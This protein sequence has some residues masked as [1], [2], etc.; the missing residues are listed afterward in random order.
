VFV[1]VAPGAGVDVTKQQV[2]FRDPSPSRTSMSYYTST[3]STSTAPTIVDAGPVY[4]SGPLVRRHRSKSRTGRELRADVRA[5]ESELRHSHS[6]GRHGE[7]VR[8]ERLSD[9]QL[10]LVEERVE[11]IEE[12]RR[13]PR[14]EKDKKGRMAISVPKYG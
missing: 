7:L 14:I 8:A 3:G 12:G 5:L 6:H 13:G 1:N 11:R 4:T 9:G 2:A 10:V